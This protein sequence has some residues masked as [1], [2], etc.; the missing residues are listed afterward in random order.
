MNDESHSDAWRERHLRRSEAQGAAPRGPGLRGGRLSRNVSP[1]TTNTGDINVLREL[2]R[3]DL[4][5]RWKKI[6]P[7]D[8]PKNLGQAL[9]VRVLAYE[10]QAQR[11]GGLRSSLC[12]TMSKT[13][14]RTKG[15]L[16]TAS[17]SSS[18]KSGT[19]LLRDWNG[20]THVVD[21]T[22][23]GYQWNGETYR[24]LSA[25]ARAITGARWSG[26]RFFGVG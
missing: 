6:L 10:L 23:A 19:R 11:F 3:S 5:A 17:A 9:L 25:I 16:A 24:S 12:R 14:A 1:I 21:V 26:P 2:S 15:Q 8:P 22:A 18:L 20:R 13:A 7:S 4:V